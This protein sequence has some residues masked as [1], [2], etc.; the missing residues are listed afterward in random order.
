[1]GPPIHLTEIH[2]GCMAHVT[3]ISHDA[4]EVT[5]AVEDVGEMGNF[6]FLITNKWRLFSLA[7]QY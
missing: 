2:I 7:F 4:E 1:M 6:S 5:I 3:E